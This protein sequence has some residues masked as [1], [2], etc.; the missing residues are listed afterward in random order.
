M[1]TFIFLFL[2]NALASGNSLAMWLPIVIIFV[3]MYFLI[4]RPQAKRQKEHQKMLTALVKGDQVVTSGG[5]HGTIMGEKDKD[6]TLIVKISD[7]VK[8]EVSRSNISRKVEKEK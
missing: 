2:E 4:L 1:P 3:I 6:E 8:V 5:I 7:N